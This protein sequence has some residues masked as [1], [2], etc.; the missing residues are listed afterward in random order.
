MSKL[1]PWIVAPVAVVLAS[2]GG[3]PVGERTA[4]VTSSTP[5]NGDVGVAALLQ[6]DALVCSATLVSSRVLLTAAHCVAGDVLPDVYFGSAPSPGAPHVALLEAQLHPGFDATTLADDIALALLADPAPVGATPWPLPPA[7]LS[8]GAVGLPL[9]LVGF[10][11]TSASD[12]SPPQK[13]TGTSVIS[14]LNDTQLSFGPSP[15]Q[16]C[17]GDS[18]G[19]AFATF[20]GVEAVVGVTSSGDSGCDVQATDTRVDAFAS[21]FIAPYLAATA[22]GAAGAGDR[23]R[24][25]AN[26]AV[27]ACTPALDDPTISFCE[28]PCASGDACPAGLACL[29]DGNGVKLCRHSTPSPGSLGSP[30]ATD[31]DCFHGACATSS[32][33]G[34]RVCATACFVDLPGF[35]PMGYSCTTR[36]DLPGQAA[37]FA[38]HPQGGCDAAPGAANGP[39][40]VLAVAL[41]LLVF[42][43]RRRSRLATRSMNATTLGERCRAVG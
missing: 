26:C 38:T 32:S 14:S 8:A 17:E 31:G 1:H 13:R 15:S 5:T 29:P 4:A 33:G 7:P 12:T 10:G 18:G 40:S 34:A 3:A 21:S 20:A 19:P 22:E 16:T 42:R 25:P 6:G 30:C 39:P 9:R 11:K 2:C 23:C 37:C 28:R 24:Y 27:G 43:Q 36:A 41:L 35:C